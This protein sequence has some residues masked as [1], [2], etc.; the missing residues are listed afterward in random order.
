[1]SL[2]IVFMG[3]PEFSA[4]CLEAIKNSSHDIVGVVTALDKPVG[5][6]RKLRESAIKRAAL[7]W[8]LPLLQ[9]PN[10]KAPSFLEQL[11]SLKA[12]LFVVVAFRMLPKVVWTI[13]PKGTINLH[14]SLLP[15]YR[16][17]APINWAIINREIKT[18]VT[19][20][21]I[22]D[23]IDTGEI[24]MQEE[25][26]I[27]KR[28]TA[29][30]LHDKLNGVGNK[31]LMKTI[32]GIE[33]NRI[34]SHPQKWAHSYHLAPKLSP[35]NCKIDWNKPSC[36]IEALIRGL[37]PYPLAWT[38]LNKDGNKLKTK[39]HSAVI[40]DSMAQHKPGEIF[41]K[42]RKLYVATKDGYLRLAELQIESKRKL[43][44]KSFLNGFALDKMSRFE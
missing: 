31:I 34:E 15:N 4:P 41:I 11:R 17:A 8:G 29:G 2:K 19:T 1:M 25:V 22:N 21:Y 16:G 23:K 35:E 39:I 43:T 40:D 6:G 38:I 27:E 24:L 14:A 12:D 5:R 30:S 28:E 36:E 18:G 20:F 3:T 10:L 9:P 13:P 37:R 7:E 42:D 32:N 44:D 26:V 33:K